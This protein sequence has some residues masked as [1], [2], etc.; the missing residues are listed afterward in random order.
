MS[1]A[2]GV[3]FPAMAAE[4]ASPA[5]AQTACSFY[6]VLLTAMKQGATLGFD[7]RRQLLEPEIRRDFDLP[8]MTRLVVGLPWR[9]MTATVQ[10]EL[11]EAFSNFS[12]ATYANEFRGYS[13]ERF[14]VDPAA[15]PLSTGDVIV[16]TKLVTGDGK[17]VQLDCLMR[18]GADCWQI[19]DVYLTGTIS[20]LAARRSE[21][22]S[23]LRQGGAEALIKLLK[24]KAAGLR[25]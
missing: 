24:E 9:S 6:A 19:I 8:L 7:G 15:T 1:L 20:E 11:V 3:A 13:G 4:P 12:I 23:V 16:H 2:F 25:A 18:K 5:P 21:F 14:V 17:M 22:S 10:Q